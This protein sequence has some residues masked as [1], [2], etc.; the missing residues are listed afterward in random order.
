[1]RHKK[2]SRPSRLLLVGFGKRGQQWAEEV[3]REKDALVVGVVDPDPKARAFAE[4]ARLAA[5][6][7]LEPALATSGD[8]KSVV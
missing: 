2:R 8:R 4:K 6:D 3:A 7:A 1:M 5:W